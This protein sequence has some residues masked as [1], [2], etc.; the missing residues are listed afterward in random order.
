MLQAS[1]YFATS[2]CAR[3][4]SGSTASCG[5][6]LGDDD[7]D[8]YPHPRPAARQ[9]RRRS[10]RRSCLSIGDHSRP[11]VTEVPPD[12]SA[13]RIQPPVR[14]RWLSIAPLEDAD[15]SEHALRSG[16]GTLRSEG[17][18]QDR[19]DRGWSAALDAA[20]HRHRAAKHCS[21]ALRLVPAMPRRHHVALPRRHTQRNSWPRWN[22]TPWSSAHAARMP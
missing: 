20:A 19:S 2:A 22:R 3:L 11:R 5:P 21:L 8:V 16:A 9:R 13:A 14:P 6:G 4:P 1:P 18:R 17:Q 12:E 10:G 15:A 7:G